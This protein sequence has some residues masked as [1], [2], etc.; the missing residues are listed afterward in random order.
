MEGDKTKKV[1][2]LI[3]RNTISRGSKSYA[4]VVGNHHELVKSENMHTKNTVITPPEP[5]TNRQQGMANKAKFQFPPQNPSQSRIHMLLQF[6]PNSNPIKDIRKLRKGLTV[7]L[8]EGGQRSVSWDLKRNPK[9][10]TT[11]VPWDHSTPLH[12]LGK[13]GFEFNSNT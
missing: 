9:N 10:D 7:T 2:G 11:W 5:E 12:N 8:N 13:T 1:Q 6:F 3:A 4:G